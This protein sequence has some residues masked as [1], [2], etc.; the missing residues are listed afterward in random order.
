MFSF[1]IFRVCVHRDSVNSGNL[2]VDAD[3]CYESG[4]YSLAQ[5]VGSTRETPGEPQSLCLRS[6]KP[7][8]RLQTILLHGTG[9]H[10]LPC[11]DGEAE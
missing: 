10:D 11:N 2:P 1:S 4:T 6:L 9:V 5:P 3:S 8:R 7:L